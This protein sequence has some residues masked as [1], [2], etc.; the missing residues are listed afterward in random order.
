MCVCACVC[1]GPSIVVFMHH[2]RGVRT[3]IE[4]E[5]VQESYFRYMEENPMAGVILEED[6]QLEYDADGNVILPNRKVDK[7]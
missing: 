5:D 2:F 7:C 6:E 4:N 3:D 1:T